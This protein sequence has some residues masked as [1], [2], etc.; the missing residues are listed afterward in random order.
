LFTTRCKRFAEGGHEEDARLL[1]ARLLD[2]GRSFGWGRFF[3]V[4]F[5]L[6]ENCWRGIAEGG[7]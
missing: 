4:G 2:K 5:G 1:D 6:K 3:D 7:K